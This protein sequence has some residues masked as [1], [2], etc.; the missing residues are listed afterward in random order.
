MKHSKPHYHHGNLRNTL[1]EQ[2][3]KL[4]EEVGAENFS[5]REAASLAGVSPNAAYRH[6]AGKPD[7][8]MAVA[9]AGI[10]CQEQY[11]QRAISAVGSC[12]TPAAAAVE[13]LK[14]AGRAYVAFALD[15]PELLRVMLGT[16][17][18]AWV[19]DSG[20]S[21][22]S[23]YALLGKLLDDLVKEGV[24]PAGRRPGA[25]LK[26]W[27]V[28]HGFAS[29]VMQGIGAVVEKGTIRTGALESVLD[30]AMEGVCGK[31]E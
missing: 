11:I 20:T 10:S 27:T 24:L 26:A 19:D 16:R 6:F 29:L 22:P 5:L 21:K 31:V 7:L 28:V 9:E 2:S 3:V 4:V 1:I 30:F 13:R 15:H 18:P 12:P 8:L 23:S 25:E 17:G 14:A